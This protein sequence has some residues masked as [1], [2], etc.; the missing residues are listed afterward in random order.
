MSLHKMN[1]GLMAIIKENPGSKTV[2]IDAWMDA[3]SIHEPARINGIA[4][5]LEHMLFKGTER[6]GVG[7]IDRTIEAVGGVWNAGTANDFMHCYLSVAAQYFPVGLDVMADVLENSL[8]DPEEVEKERQVILEEYRRKQ[9][10]PAGFLFEEVYE[11]SYLKSPYRLPVLGSPE[12]IKAISRQDLLDYYHRYYAPENITLLVIGDIDTSQT[13]NEIRQAFKDFDRKYNPF[14]SPD[15]KTEYSEALNK[16]YERDVKETYLALSFP[17][18]SIVEKPDVYAMDVLLYILG[19]G[20]SSRL[21]RRLKE[22]LQL[23]SGIGVGYAT[24]RYQGLTVISATLSDV[25][26]DKAKAAIVEELEKLK[27]KGIGKREL[28]KAK[29]LLTNSYYFSNET[30]SGQA[31]SIGFYYNLTGSLDF[32]QHYLE[33]INRLNSDDIIK[34]ARKYLKPETMN[35]FVIKPKD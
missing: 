18:P 27:K 11:K 17:A 16:V 26:L 15:A 2:S 25:N 14:P 28:A 35:S 32:E 29:R 23:V 10:D 24:Q 12:T 1:N 4:H 21:Y 3:G 33:N 13:L 6:R 8:L 34:A 7:E 22:E 30:N 9:D 31:A 20:R 5:F 19:E